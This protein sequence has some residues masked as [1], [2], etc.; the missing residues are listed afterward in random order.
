MTVEVPP[1]YENGVPQDVRESID[2]GLE[3]AW[4]A[5]TDFA[6]D[7]WDN[8]SDGVSGAWNAVFG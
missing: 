3:N 8:V 5:T 7:A 6:E 2:A 1:A 4:D